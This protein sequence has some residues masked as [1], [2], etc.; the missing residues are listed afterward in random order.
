MPIMLRSVVLV[1]ALCVSGAA[2]A[3]EGTIR[4]AGTVLPPQM[5]NPYATS[6]TPTIT[7]TSAIYDGLTRLS[8]DGKLMPWLAVS[9]S[10]VDAKT[11]RFQLRKDV[12]FS[13][14][15]PFT[16]RD[17]AA[18]VNYLAKG[19]RPTDNILRDL[20]PLESAAVVDDFTVDI[21]TKTPVP[22]FPRYA[23]ILL[24]PESESFLRLGTEEFSKTPVGTGP[25][26]VEKW[27]PNKATL[28]AFEKSWRKPK[29]A[30][31]EILTLPEATSR[32]Q[33]VIS[34]RADVAVGLGPDDIQGLEAAGGKGVSWR[35]GSVAGI[36]LVNTREGP[37]QDVRVR[38]A[39]NYAVNRQ[40]IVDVIYQGKTVPANQPA[41]RD[42]L[43]YNEALPM[44]DFDPAKARKMLAEAGYPKGFK[45]VMEMS[46]TNSATLAA[47]Q[48]VA[49]DLANVGVTMEIRPVQLAQYLKN[50]FITGEF[51][52]AISIPW[53]SNP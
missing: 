11:W 36:S 53:S 46:G 27:E 21:V 1:A 50:N 42:V 26:A 34:G 30:V 13:N 12:L 41:A 14:G 9:W 38:R 29:E 5:G 2:S 8:S 40:P 47:Y 22:T 32:V 15:K 52:D 6:A 28:K 51:A 24:M 7:T 35:D 44:F 18:N 19:S 20:P 33:A 45:F 25:F 16:A 23:T 4:M 48:Q 17:V 10:N 39:L 3:V 49:A 37:L 31:L 43:G